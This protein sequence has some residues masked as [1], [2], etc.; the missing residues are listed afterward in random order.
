MKLAEKRMIKEIKDLLNDKKVRD[1]KNRFV[2]EGLK[3][4][5]DLISK[6]KRIAIVIVSKSFYRDPERKQLIDGWMD[7]GID[8]AE[9]ADKEFDSLS[10]L[11]NSQGILAVVEKPEWEDIEDLSS[12][13]GVFVL[14]DGVQDPGNVGTMIRTSVAFGV[15][16][17]FL[18][19]AAVD[20]Y[21][22]KVVRG[23]SGTIL[24]IPIYKCGF[25]KVKRLK[26]NGF[27]IHVS[28]LPGEK[29]G[30]CSIQN[31]QKDNEGCII[32]VFGSEAR[33]VSD[34]IDKLADSFFYIPMRR[35]AES[36]NVSAA[37]AISLYAF[38]R[39]RA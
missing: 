29:P 7:K 37:F 30:S 28:A 17:I 5:S 39:E 12:K 20:I 9:M 2:A 32:L 31:M 10:S 33:G 25:D 35:H 21:N 38:T 26:D 3:L 16:G 1:E 18:T 4:V 15:K 11:E 22:P 23:A 13:S 27:T 34:E 19:G 14:L 6:E 8:T 24:D 36:L